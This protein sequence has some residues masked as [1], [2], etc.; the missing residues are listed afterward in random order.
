MERRPARTLAAAGMLGSLLLG[1]WLLGGVTVAAAQEAAVAPGRDDTGVRLT[2]GALRDAAARAD[3][4]RSPAPGIDAVGGRLRVEVLHSLPAAEAR[5]AVVSAGGVIE[6][7]VPGVLVQATVPAD[8]LEQLEQRPGIDQLR[9]PLAVSAPLAQATTAPGPS[10]G[11]GAAQVVGQEVAKTNAGAWHA[12]RPGRRWACA[13]ASSTSY[14]SRRGTRPSPPARCPR[15]PGRSA[16]NNGARLRRLGQQRRPRPGRG[17]D[18]P[19]DGAG[20]PRCSW[21]PSRPPATSRPRSTG[22]PARGCASSPAPSGRPTTAPATAPGRWPPWSNSAVSKGMALV[23]LRRQHRRG[24]VGP[25][26]L[27]AGALDRRRQRRLVGVHGPAT[28]S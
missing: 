21:P 28:R 4:G 20:L 5:A 25:R 6:G 9:P 2:N 15:R 19:R 12:A 27:L 7:E 16:G 24:V 10:A 23:Q 14:S 22:S 26:Y 11:G 17:R 3:S 13:S 1:P 8:Q 18:R